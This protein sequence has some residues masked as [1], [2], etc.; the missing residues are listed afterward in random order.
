M[1]TKKH[2]QKMKLCNFYITQKQYDNFKKL[3]EETGL[4]YSELIRR[5]LDLFLE[6]HK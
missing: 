4:C 2:T 5:A 3:S 6:Q 1:N